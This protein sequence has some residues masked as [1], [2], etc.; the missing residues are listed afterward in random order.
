[1]KYGFIAL[2]GTIWTNNNVDIYNKLS[3][4]IELDPN[5]ERL[6]DERHKFFVLASLK[7][8]PKRAR[9]GVLETEFS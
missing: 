3:V 5:N 9:I 6:K 2:N 4:Q 1:M 7:E 8:T